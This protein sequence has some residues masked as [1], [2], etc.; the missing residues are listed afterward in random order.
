MRCAWGLKGLTGGAIMSAPASSL[1]PASA[2]GATPADLTLDT[3]R[4]AAARIA[5]PEQNAGMV[6]DQPPKVRGDVDHD[7]ALD[8][9]GSLRLDPR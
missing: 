4:A 8:A 3:V 1:A 6:V 7:E 2:P 5:D 9:M